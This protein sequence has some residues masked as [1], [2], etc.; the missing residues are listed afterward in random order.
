[1]QKVSKFKFI[2]YGHIKKL[3]LYMPRLNFDGIPKS[4]VSDLQIAKSWD[5]LIFKDWIWFFF[6]QNQKSEVFHPA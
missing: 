3:A 2:Q 1:M 4:E 6:A 5:L